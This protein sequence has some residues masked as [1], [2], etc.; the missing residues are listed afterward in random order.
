MNIRRDRYLQ[1]LIDRMGNRMIKIVTGLR[2]VGKSYLMFHIFTDYLKSAGVDDAHIISM[3]MDNLENSEFRN[4]LTL[5]SYIKAKITDK[6]MHY[7]LLDEVQMI[8]DFEELLNTLLHIENADVYV[9]G[10]NSK[11]L[12]KDVITEFRGR[13]DEVHLYPL[14]FAEFMSV[15]QGNRYDGWKEYMT[16]GGLPFV[17]SRKTPQQKSE[18]LRT[19]FTETYLKDILARNNFHRNGNLDTL[20]DILSSSVG[21]LTNPLRI[22]NTFKTVNKEDVSANTVGK[23]LAALEDSFLITGVKRYNI[24]G[25]HYIGSPLKY[26]FEDVGLRNARLNFRQQEENYIMENIIY[27][28]LRRRGFDVDV[29]VVEKSVRDD[30]GKVVRKQLEVDFVANKGYKRFYVQSAFSFHD[31]DKIAQEE[32]SLLSIDDSFQRVIVVGD[33]FG[34][35]YMNNN[36][37][38]VTGLLDFLLDEETVN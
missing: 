3:D 38:L 32:T 7:I 12:S 23:Y 1:E 13:G 21:S 14:S 37:F 29:G 6:K 24:R 5:L 10:S 4:P 20:L 31:P 11:F 27:L 2:R 26:Y 35:K 15:Y 34:T 18:Y 33:S 28:E 22:A 19:L 16:F 9:T 8:E 25:R 17:L 36:G 30:N